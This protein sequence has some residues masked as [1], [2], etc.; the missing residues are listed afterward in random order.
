MQDVTVSMVASSQML[1]SSKH[2][3]YQ[4]KLKK[5]MLAEFHWVNAML[6]SMISEKLFFFW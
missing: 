5:K 2:Q 3:N 4:T 1:I 6:S